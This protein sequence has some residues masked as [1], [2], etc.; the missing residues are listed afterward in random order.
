MINFDK[1][2]I[3][4]SLSI[5]DIFQLLSDW[6]GDPEYTLSGIIASTICHNAPGEGS[7]KL[8]FYI[9]SQLFHC[10]T[11]CEDPTFDIFELVRKVASIQ[12][13]LEYDL[14]AAVRW[15]AQ[16]FGLSG[17]YQIIETN[18]LE[19]WKYL[20]NYDRIKELTLKVDKVT[21]KE[22]DDSILNNLNYNIKIRPWLDEGI[23]QEAIDKARIGYYLTTD[24]I[25]IPHF[26]VDGRFIGLRGRAMCAEDIE[27][28]GKYRPIKI[29]KQT[30]NHPLGFNLYN[31][32]NSK[33]NIGLI[34]KAIVFEGEKSTLLYRS[35]FE[36]DIS[37]ACCG[38]SVSIYQI[39]ALIEA[40]AQEI[41]IA[42][43]RQFQELGDSEFKKLTANLK[44]I[45]QKYKNE[46]VISFIF[47]KEMITDYKASPI[48]HG[49]DVFLH[50]FKK[51]IFL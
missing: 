47:D 48:D 10:Y 23:T 40:G 22:Y 45:H 43:D 39:N 8:Y 2:Q 36:N 51:R 21:L 50:L 35:Y 13:G 27:R 12:W 4:E 31:L 16:R 34:Q 49:P 42:F 17:E 44:K 41:I 9:N 37:V 25:T 15:V 46:A 5:E 11:G 38:S 30:Y 18:Q 3:K 26:D 7:R 19:D 32:N 33:K 29:G 28:W 24:Q 1:N 14:N 20:D 6:G